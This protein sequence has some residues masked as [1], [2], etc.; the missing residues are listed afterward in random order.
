M[1]TDCSSRGLSISRGSGQG[2]QPGWPQTTNVTK[3]G[4][5]HLSLLPLTP[6]CRDC[7]CQPPHPVVGSTGTATWWLT[8]TYNG[9]WCPT[10]LRYSL[11]SSF[12]PFTILKVSF[13]DLCL[14]SPP[15]CCLGFSFRRV[16]D[17]W[18]KCA[19]FIFFFIFLVFRCWYLHIC[20]G[21]SLFHCLSESLP[22]EQPSFGG[23]IPRPV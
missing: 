19:A 8:A 4:F 13:S 10:R 23:S 18:D 16:G 3:D 7:R 6:V 1:S 5:E 21:G 15:L 22:R 12:K 20:W 17:S 9:A 14:P 11:L 2:R